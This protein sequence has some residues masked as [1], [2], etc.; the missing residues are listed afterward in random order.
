MGAA[1]LRAEIAG[2][3]PLERVAGDTGL[4]AADIEWLSNCLA[5]SKEAWIKTGIGWNRRRNGAMSMRAVCSL[6][7]VLGIAGRLHFESGDHFGL[8]SNWLS[9]PE[10]MGDRGREPIR[11]IEL[12]RE[13]EAGHFRGAFVWGHNPAVVLPESGR[14]RAGLAR[15]DLFLVVHELVLTETARLADVVLPATALPEYTDVFKSYGHR[16]MQISRKVCDAPDEQRSNLQTFASIAE[17]LGLDEDL[18]RL[19]EEE[20]LTGFLQHHRSRF[21]DEEFER[22]QRGEPVKLQPRTGWARGTPS[23]RIELASEQCEEQGQGR[24]AAYVPDDGCEM[25][26]RFW[27]HPTPSVA[28]HN[29]TYTRSDRHLRRAGSPQV[30][31]HPDDAQELG[32]TVGQGVRLHNEVGSLTLSLALSDDAPR[33]M[34]RLEGF[35]DPAQIPEG[36]ST[37]ALTRAAGSDLA[38]GFCQFSARVDL[39]PA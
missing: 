8:D 25:A 22:L 16:V 7:A 20:L 26:G 28:T 10:R 19:D 6:A 21:T 1:E 24:V 9:Q 17:R 2:A 29:S 5:N 18:F 15:D 23:G 12:G 4:A 36:L 14:V 31:V 33:G 39:S 38:A 13:L 30:W 3:Y 37:N 32:L 27:L 35:P 34:V 11:H